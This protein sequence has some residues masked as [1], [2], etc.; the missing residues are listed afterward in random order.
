M[1]IERIMKK[2]QTIPAQAAFTEADNSYTYR[3]LGDAVHQIVEQLN[4]L[5]LNDR[6]ILVFG[7]NNFLSLAAMLASNAVGHAYIPVD[8]H[9]PLERVAAI[10]AAS[11]PALV[12]STSAID[13]S[14]KL[15][16]GEPLLIT[17]FQANAAFDFSMLDLSRAVSGH[18][19]TYIIYTSGTTGVPKGV[20]VSHD[21]LASF[22]AWMLSDFEQIVDNKY[23]AQPLFSFDL[24]IFSLYPSLVSGGELVSLSRDEVG[25]FKKLF[26]RLNQATIN[27]WISTP[28]FV[29]M[30]LVDPSFKQANHAALQQF[31][32]CGEELT[33]KTARR[34][35]EKFPDVKIYNTYGPTEATGAISS[36]L[37]DD[38]LLAANDRLPVG[39][40]KPGVKLAVEQ[41]EIIIMGDSVG[42]G[43]FE[44]PQK[45]RASFVT[46]EGQPAFKT[47]DAGSLDADG[48]LHYQG[49]MD[50]QVKFNGYRIEL[51]DIEA[52]L[53][54]NEHV[55]Q[56][57]M[58][59]RY[60]EEH[61]VTA[62]IAVIKPHAYSTD[63]ATMRQ[64][65]KAIKA[66][67]L[68]RV[69]DYMLPTKFVYFE[70]LPLNQNGKIDRKLL[71]EKVAG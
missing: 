38:K 3:D 52:N 20:E 6:P 34:L 61:K 33:L 31:I 15:V 1:L 50:F 44:N 37:I 17:E 8:E 35:Q 46:I 53:V 40:A 30:L 9:T 64:I 47:G 19:T 18:A 5:A 58:I 7:R 36:V 27:T 16:L 41:G 43:Y 21:N 59:P 4:Q 45:T 49:R 69:M 62:L 39:K 66:D 68:T 24:S 48:M 60:N 14:T 71:A 70:E 22:V 26:E 51:Q 67:L 12:I 11:K 54:M 57:V 2:A 28:S 29:D 10:V 23:L 25:N 13:G 32:F 55:E 56:A 63:K 65:S 42:N